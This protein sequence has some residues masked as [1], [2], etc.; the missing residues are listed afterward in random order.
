MFV[1]HMIKVCLVVSNYGLERLS[2]HVI[3]KGLVNIKGVALLD[4]Q[5]KG[6]YTTNHHHDKMFV[7]HSLV[8]KEQKCRM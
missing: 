8:D 7:V 5:I 2:N 3:L 6:N 4:V 1:F